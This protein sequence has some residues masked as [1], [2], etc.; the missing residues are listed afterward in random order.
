MP[1]VKSKSDDAFKSNLKAE[2]AAG[3]PR[4]QSLA[5]AYSVKRKARADGGGVHVGPIISDVPGRTD[6]HPMDVA[7]GSYVVPAYAV[8]HL[9]EN[10]TLAGMKV[11]QHM[12]GD[13][14]NR[15]SGGQVVPIAAAGGEY[16][17][18][19]NKVAE[20]GGGDMDHGHKVLDAWVMSLKRD[21]IKTLKGLARPAQ[22]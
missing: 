7:A 11:L 2:L 10:N 19:P 5:I 12:F 21:H 9:G 15:A 1:L 18:P 16:V 17:I 13:I 14:H 3:K 8:S 22:D 20:I 4:D 6:S